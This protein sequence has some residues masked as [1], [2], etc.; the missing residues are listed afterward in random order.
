MPGMFDQ[1]GLDLNGLSRGQVVVEYLNPKFSAGEHPSM[2]RV[3]PVDTPGPASLAMSDVSDLI[4]TIS[5]HIYAVTAAIL[6]LF[7]IQYLCLGLF[8]DA[9][10]K[11]I[12]PGEVFEETMR[13]V[14]AGG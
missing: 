6:I 2:V 14:R 11:P 10:L 8:V 5:L 13:R 9:S 12:K 1:T 3:T 4:S 7:F